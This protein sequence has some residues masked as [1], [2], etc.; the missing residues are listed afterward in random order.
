[1]AWLPLCL[2][3]LGCSGGSGSVEY[4]EVTGRVLYD[5]KPLP[6]GTVTFLAVKGGFSGGGAI[7][8]NGNYKAEAPVGPV[9]IAVENRML[10]QGKGGAG[11]V[12]RS[13]GMKQR[14][15]K[16][17]ESVTEVRPQGHYVPIP[18]KYN[19]P[20]QSG[21]TYTV[22]KGAQTHDIILGDNPAAS[23]AP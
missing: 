4:A 1:M 21:L 22:E 5:G 9:L 3:A 20:D 19:F 13:E 16:S 6:G 8:E 17:T 12:N 11:R 2:L 10:V 15:A 23:G 14:G 7:D 18:G